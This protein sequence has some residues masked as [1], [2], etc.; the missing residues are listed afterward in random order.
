MHPISIPSPSELDDAGLVRAHTKITQMLNAIAPP[1]G[2]LYKGQ[3]RAEMVAFKEEVEAAILGGPRHCLGS[4]TYYSSLD[5][6]ISHLLR[7]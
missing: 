7:C 5:V 2:C 1:F 3:R 6:R 4:L